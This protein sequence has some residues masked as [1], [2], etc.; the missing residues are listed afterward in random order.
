MRVVPSW[1]G[2]ELEICGYGCK[3][4]FLECDTF[5]QCWE[6]LARLFEMGAADGLVCD[7]GVPVL[8][9]GVRYNCRVICR[10]RRLLLIRPTTALADGGNYREGRYFATY[11][12]PSA[13]AAERHLLPAAFLSEFGQ[14]DAPFGPHH[15]HCADG[16]TV[17]CESCEELWPP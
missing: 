8:H 12:A 5:D 9:G 6:S 17:G 14:R 7:F 1:L 11:S 10:D 16:T 13:S 4:H 3:D 15:L 2:P